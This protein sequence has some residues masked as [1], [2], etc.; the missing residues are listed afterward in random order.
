MKTVTNF[1]N[2][3]AHDLHLAYCGMDTM[4]THELFGILEP[5]LE[6]V[7]PIY[8]FEK[9]LLPPVHTM[10]MRGI[11]INTAAR[12]VIVDSAQTR[13]DGYRSTLNELTEKVSG[14]PLNPNSHLQLKKFFYETLMIPTQTQSKAGVRSITCNRIA[15]ER[16]AKHYPLARPFVKLILNIRD[17]EKQ[18]QTLNKALAKGDRWSAGYNVAGTDTGRWSSSDHPL[19]H[20][21]N[22]QN[23]DPSLREVFVAEPDHY[24]VYCDLAGAEARAVAYLSED[25]NYIKAVEESDV[26]SQVASMVFGVSPDRGSASGVDR[27]FYRGFTYRDIAKRLTHG[28]NYYG[29]ARTLAQV[30][31]VET[32]FVQEFQRKFFRSFPGIRTWHQSVARKIQQDQ[33]ITTP[34]GRRRIFYERTWSDHTLRKA[35]AFGPQS[36]VADIM[37]QGLK[38]VWQELEPQVKLQGMIHDAII[39]SIPIKNFDEILKRVL[40]CLTITVEVYQREMTIPVDAEYGLNWGKLSDKNPNGLKKWKESNA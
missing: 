18:C 19:R 31:Q 32:K 1:E 37:A 34:L 17:L 11:Q 24:L 33:Q 29:S 20:S 36:L 22:V 10:M 2:L 27:E 39:A 13:I 4:L 25:L 21:A 30:A 23:I 12:K 28:T 26:H 5:K 38:K 40:K 9:S 6:E 7:R 15:L 35:I 14:S 16:I 8:E 3:N